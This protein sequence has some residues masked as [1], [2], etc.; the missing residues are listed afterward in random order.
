MYVRMYIIFYMYVCLYIYMYV[1]LCV[2][3]Y[4]CMYVCMYVG[5]YMCMYFCILQ[6]LL[7][8]YSLIIV[9]CTIRYIYVLFPIRIF[10][11]Y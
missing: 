11:N 10:V 2:G 5:L 6:H 1:C 7:Y 8:S 4:V 3:L 9:D